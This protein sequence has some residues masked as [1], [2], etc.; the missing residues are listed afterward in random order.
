LIKE[1]PQIKLENSSKSLTDGN[2]YFG[3]NKVDSIF[4]YDSSLFK[5]KDVSF[6][7]ID[8]QNNI[9]L[10][11]TTIT[12]N[13]E[14][15][16]YFL[17]SEFSSNWSSLYYKL[18][19]EDG[20]ILHEF[21]DRPS[22]NK[23]EGRLQ[24][25][26]IL[27]EGISTYD[28][29]ERKLFE[30]IPFTN[31]PDRLISR[32][33]YIAVEYDPNTTIADF[34]NYKRELEFS[35]ELLDVF[36]Q[37]GPWPFEDHLGN[38]YFLYYQLL[39]QTPNMVIHNK[40]G[41]LQTIE[42]TDFID[43]RNIEGLPTKLVVFPIEDTHREIYGMEITSTKDLSKNTAYLSPNPV[44]DILNIYGDN[45]YENFTIYDGT[46]KFIKQ[47]LIDDKVFTVDVSKLRTGIYFIK[48]NKK[49]NGYE[50]KRFI[51]N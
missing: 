17:V 25:V 48:L 23:N 21:P 46:G 41:Y 33:K 3:H 6:D 51:K 40:E 5:L 13:N 9:G 7:F 20:I 44:N 22:I 10:T 49:D 28:V 4:I 29:N 12:E 8:S 31:S 27:N 34:Y 14:T 30:L 50:V 26:H 37:A 36:Y 16:I 19:D 38:D 18:I 11:M 45:D 2:Y 32:G 47:G 39:G 35:V 24:L 1:M 15:S 43:A 42:N